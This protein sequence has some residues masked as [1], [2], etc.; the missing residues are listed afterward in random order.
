MAKLALRPKRSKSHGGKGEGTYF[1][2]FSF[3]AWEN[4]KIEGKQLKYSTVSAKRQGSSACALWASV[5]GIG[6]KGADGHSKH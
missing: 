6:K 2:R 5:G 3:S 4:R 1:S